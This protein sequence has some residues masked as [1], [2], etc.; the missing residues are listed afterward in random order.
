MSNSFQKFIAV[1]T[2]GYKSVMRTMSSGVDVINLS[3]ATDEYWRDSNNKPC[4][5]TEWH[6]A[7]FY[8]AKA[9]KVNKDV[10]K[11]S[12]IHIEGKISTRFWKDDN[13]AEQ[14]TKEIIVD[15]FT[16]FMAAADKQA[17][18]NN[19]DSERSSGESGSNGTQQQEVISKHN[20]NNKPEIEFD[21]DG[22]PF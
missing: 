3:I 14:T 16:I 2:V 19:K 6:K 13:G 10:K 12:T 15:N 20:P 1:G 9:D 18:K 21:D 8:G 22:T 17:Y 11:G 4:K 7:V 5:K